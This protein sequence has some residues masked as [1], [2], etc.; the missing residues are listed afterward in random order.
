MSLVIVAGCVRAPQLQPTARVIDVE[1]EEE[2]EDP[3]LGPGSLGLSI[4]SAVV[5]VVSAFAAVQAGTEAYE[6]EQAAEYILVHTPREE[7]SYQYSLNRRNEQRTRAIAFGAVALAGL[8]GAT[9]LYLAPR[10]EGTSGDIGAGG[11]AAGEDG[12]F[13]LAGGIGGFVLPRLEL[14]L[15]ASTTIG[16]LWLGTIGPTANLWL[17]E[18][19]WVG[20]GAVG[21]FA[22]CGGCD[23]WAGWGASFRAG[24]VFGS[25]M[26]SLE[27]R[28]ASELPSA[29]IIVG[30]RFGYSKRR[31]REKRQEQREAVEAKRRKRQEAAAATA[32]A[33]C[34]SRRE[35]DFAWASAT[36]D[37]GERAAALDAIKPCGDP[38][39]RAWGWIRDAARHAD[40]DRCAAIEPY[41]VDLRRV[42]PAL[43]AGPFANDPRI[44]QCLA[45]APKE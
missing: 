37:P 34:V 23:G 19:A 13:V 25:F 11:G 27:V 41:D 17:A 22:S 24:L 7:Q 44:A 33:E 8:G 16:T 1:N 28:A 43:H 5:A 36:T 38:D 12:G 26:T 39:D 32:R 18:Y 21:S 31:Y 4:A 42:A 30:Y 10:G 40:E 35:A 45:A 2:V 3:P 6:A 15:G 9:A 20:A 29:S 14:R